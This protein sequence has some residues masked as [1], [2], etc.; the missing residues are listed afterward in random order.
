[1]KSKY[2]I[3]WCKQGQLANR[4]I[5]FAHLIGF[6][7]QYGYKLV[8]FTFYDYANIFP[9]LNKDFLCRY[10]KARFSFQLSLFFRKILYRIIFCVGNKSRKCKN[11]FLSSYN[12]SN[13][14]EVK[15]LTDSSCFEAF[16][17][18]KIIL[19]NGWMLRDYKSLNKHKEIIKKI[20]SP[21]KKIQERILNFISNLRNLNSSLVGIHIRRGDYKHFRGGK[22]YFSFDIYVRIMKRMMELLNNNVTFLI[23][24]NETIDIEIFND[25]NCVLGLG[26]AIEDLYSLSECDF[27]IGPPSTFSIW[28]SFYGNKPFYHINDA[29]KLFFLKD[30]HVSEC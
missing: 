13:E 12:Y 16:N 1:M 19:V 20:F 23:C 4:I 5:V 10:P 18:S 28:A 25:L 24:T 29:S 9:E 15:L 14:E 30:F 8:N 3:L 7:H 21:D 17:R 22:Y 26:S 27:I 6:A 2:L 11:K